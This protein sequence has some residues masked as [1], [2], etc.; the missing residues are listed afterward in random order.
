MTVWQKP[1]LRRLALDL[2]AA[3]LMLV[4]L[5]Y[6]WLDN[7]VHEL[8]GTGMFVLLV[9]HNTLNRRWYGALPGSRK[10]PRHR[11][12]IVL[13]FCLLSTMLVLLATSLMISRT[14]FSSV[15]LPDSV[16]AR[17]VHALAAYWALV[18][19][20]I[21]VGIRW[22]RILVLLGNAFGVLAGNAS[23]A[24][25]LRCLA[26]A[27]A[28][29]GIYSSFQ[30]DIGGKL[31]LQMSLDWWDFQESIIGFFLH[32]VAVMGLYAFLAHHAMHWV[33]RRIHPAP[34]AWCNPSPPPKVA[35]LRHPLAP[36]P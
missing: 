30:M 1:I 18:L 29:G 27:I 2:T 34:S 28:A 8:V 15:S 3:A 5:A 4:A 13:V 11:I 35:E 32:H 17:R 21:H 20:A 23:R 25:V 7:S 22:R 36:P 33:Q 9:A 6:Y 10:E 24:L 14:V 31:L 26:V 16:V 19:V 12:D